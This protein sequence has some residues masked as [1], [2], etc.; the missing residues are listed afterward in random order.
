MKRFS[1]QLLLTLLLFLT[2]LLLFSACNDREPCGGE[3]ILSVADTD[4]LHDPTL[5]AEESDA[6]C[7]RTVPIFDYKTVSFD[8]STPS[9]GKA[10]ITFPFNESVADLYGIDRLSVVSCREY[11][12]PLE[13]IFHLAYWGAAPVYRISRQTSVR[14]ENGLYGERFLHSMSE[15]DLAQYSKEDNER[16]TAR[17]EY[18][19]A[20]S[21]DNHD[22]YLILTFS[23]SDRLPIKEDEVQD[24]DDIVS[25]LTIEIQSDPETLS[26]LKDDFSADLTD[27][28]ALSLYSAS[29]N[30][31]GLLS[32]PPEQIE[33]RGRVL[34]ALDVDSWT[35]A[36]Y[37]HDAVDPVF[38]LSTWDFILSVY[39][40][41][42]LSLHD[43]RPAAQGSIHLFTAKNNTAD[44]LKALIS[45]LENMMLSFRPS[46]GSDL[47]FTSNRLSDTQYFLFFEQNG[48][49]AIYRTADFGQSFLPCAITG[50][51]GG[52]KS[53]KALYANHGGAADHLGMLA[54]LTY[55][56]GIEYAYYN[57]N[58]EHGV[59]SFVHESAIDSGM[60][61]GYQWPIEG[62]RYPSKN[63]PFST[64]HLV[65]ADQLGLDAN[66]SRYRFLQAFVDGESDA[67]ENFCASALP[68]GS[69]DAVS[70]LAFETY[71]AYR[72]GDDV[73]FNVMLSQS[74][75][76]S[77]P[78]GIPLRFTVCEGING[79]Y[80]SGG[81]NEPY[82]HLQVRETIDLYLDWSYAYHIPPSDDMDE[83]FRWSITEYLCAR[84][85][86][87]R[88]DGS[89]V[90]SEAELIAD[91]ETYLG[92][93][94]FTPDDRHR[95][96]DGLYDI[97][98]HGGHG[99]VY[100]ILS[101]EPSE[102]G[103]GT[104]V[105]VRFY[106]DASKIVNSHLYRYELKLTDEGQY[107]FVG[108]ERIE[109][110]VHEPLRWAV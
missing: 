13:D 3:P 52:V 4:A 91:A 47:L 42:I 5:P 20:L 14:F 1:S 67:L 2:P 72:I 88:A 73:G 64:D 43:G 85:G 22:L 26:A 97:L 65:S 84:R 55:E 98:P 27:G 24:F 33:L 74:D 29:Q 107:A 110:S 16:F 54:E 10:V 28:K 75:I 87:T 39:E 102:S 32:I 90:M 101:A 99:I 63:L 69:Y 35:E 36:S 49:T 108:C 94:S 103:Q 93:S 51:P 17:R 48:S 15:E 104:S 92:I 86:K 83:S 68:K 44:A 89:T 109:E 60:M 37:P 12:T 59:Y 8:K 45:D 71:T 70:D 46:E 9:L 79:T 81:A 78:V 106:A 50:T 18:M 100:D 105:T 19:Y 38:R 66:D 56:N 58:E 57:V 53:I 76:D 6:R 80:L 96:A 40:N 30:R 25:Q 77:L 11:G 7:Q 41:G 21:V 31:L 61:L 95:H 62:I 82:I 23:P 34:S